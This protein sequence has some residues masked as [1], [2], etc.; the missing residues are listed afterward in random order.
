[1]DSGSADF[2]VPGENCVVGDIVLEVI[3]LG[4]QEICVRLSP[5]IVIE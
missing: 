1:M 5:V 3:G 2:W 4:D